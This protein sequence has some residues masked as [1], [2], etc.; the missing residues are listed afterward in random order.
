MS[1]CFPKTQVFVV[2]N[3]HQN[4]CFLQCFQQNVCKRTKI[5]FVIEILTI[6]DVHNVLVQKSGTSGCKLKEGL[7]A[8]H[9]FGSYFNFRKRT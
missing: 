4:A 9:N 3:D 2:S 7:P 6:I 8:V 5:R 1:F